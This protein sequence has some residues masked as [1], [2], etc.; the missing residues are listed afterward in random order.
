[1]LKIIAVAAVI[2]GLH[3]AFRQLRRRAIQTANDAL[4]SFPKTEAEGRCVDDTGREMRIRHNKDWDMIGLWVTQ[5][6]ITFIAAALTAQ[7][8]P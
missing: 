6:I 1:M 8:V 2:V 3:F 7:Y 4:D 5:F